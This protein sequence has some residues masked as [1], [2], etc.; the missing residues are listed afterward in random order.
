[1]W[2]RIVRLSS[3]CYQIKIKNRK[4]FFAKYNFTICG[5]FVH[6]KKKIIKTLTCKDLTFQFK[7]CWW[8]KQFQS[9]KELAGISSFSP[10]QNEKCSNV[11]WTWLE[12][13]CAQW[14]YCINNC[15]IDWIYHTKEQFHPFF[16][17]N[18]QSI[19][20][21]F[22]SYIFSFPSIRGISLPHRHGSSSDVTM[23]N[24]ASFTQALP[25]DW[26]LYPPSHECFPETTVSLPVSH[27]PCYDSSLWMNA[28]L[29][30]VPRVFAIS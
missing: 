10:F 18:E 15:N 12:L 2:F 3:F 20:F 8:K 14:K 27:P 13:S 30:G 25:F 22:V 9:Q 11:R 17:E 4:S 5:H 23:A 28:C 24:Q 6:I 7:E 19:F 26:S 1:M 21:V 29:P 16:N